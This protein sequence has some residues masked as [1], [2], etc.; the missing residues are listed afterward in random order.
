MTGEPALLARYDGF[1]SVALC[2]HGCVHVQIGSTTLTLTEAQSQRLVA[3]LADSAADFEMQ[4]QS[5]KRPGDEDADCA[6]PATG[7]PGFP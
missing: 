2:A 4:R 7:F 5:R 3:M 6:A 1:G